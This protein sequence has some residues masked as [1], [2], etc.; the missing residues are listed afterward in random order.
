MAAERAVTPFRSN[1]V[2]IATV[3]ISMPNQVNTGM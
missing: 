2:G 1:P 3:F